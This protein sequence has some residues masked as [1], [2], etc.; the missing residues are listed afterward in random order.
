[1]NVEEFDHRVL[2]DAQ[3]LLLDLDGTLVDSSAPVRRAWTAFALR[4]GLDPA[5]VYDFAQGRPSPETIRLL[6]PHADHA[7]EAA[8][9]EHAET[10]DTGGVQALPGADAILK[11]GYPLAIVTSCSTQLAEVRLGAAGLPRPEIVI[12]SSI[13][14][15]GKPDPEGFL[16]GACRLNVA[17]QHCAV[18]EDSPAGIEAGLA[19]GA[20]VIALRTSQSDRALARADAIIDN[21]AALLLDAPGATSRHSHPHTRRPSTGVA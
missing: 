3:A 12:T 15:R 16:L 2:R 6:A 18:L 1:M 19:A 10:T 21:L 4:N 8:L 7:T 5:E 14:A 17:P 20:R 9:V 13:V 11:S